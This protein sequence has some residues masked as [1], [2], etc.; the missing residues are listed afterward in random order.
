M[1]GQESWSTPAEPVRCWICFSRVCSSILARGVTVAPPRR[2]GARASDRE[3]ARELESQ[4]ALQ[5]GRAG[6]DSWHTPA[7]PVMCWLSFSR[8]CSSI[9]P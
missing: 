2:H 4:A 8:F 7:E 6:Q 1:A 9:L 5:A 3:A